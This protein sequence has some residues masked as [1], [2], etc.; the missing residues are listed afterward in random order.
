[1]NRSIIATALGP[2]A[3]LSRL[4]ALFLE[5]TRGD[6]VSLAPLR[7][8]PAA[9]A[10]APDATGA[11][12]M[13]P[14]VPTSRYVDATTRYV[15]ATTG[16]QVELGAPDLAAPLGRAQQV[17]ATTSSTTAA[18]PSNSTLSPPAPPGPHPAVK[19]SRTCRGTR[20]SVLAGHRD[21]ESRLA[22]VGRRVLESRRLLVGRRV[23]ADRLDLGRVLADRRRPTRRRVGPCPDHR[24]QMRRRVRPCPAC[25]RRMRR[26]LRVCPECPCRPS[27][28]W[29]TT[30][31][32]DPDGRPWSLLGGHP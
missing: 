16:A 5:R 13:D 7:D 26:R 24:R 18:G 9:V 23:L 29:A 20:L 10:V 17:A 22:L 14:D 2:L 3:E 4:E 21:L 6:E 12:V 28:P 8:H 1:M 31:I 15:D 27:C 11:V 30:T 25:R 19:S 32:R